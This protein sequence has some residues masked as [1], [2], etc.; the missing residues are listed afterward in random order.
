MNRNIETDC[1]KAQSKTQEGIKGMSLGDIEK[2]I[3]EAVASN[4]NLSSEFDRIKKGKLTKGVSR[5]LLYCKFI[6]TKLGSKWAQLTGKKNSPKPPPEAASKSPIIK[7]FNAENFPFVL[8][9]EGEAVNEN[10]PQ[11]ENIYNGDLQPPPFIPYVRESRRKELD[12]LAGKP[13]RA[14]M[15]KIDAAIRRAK[16][17]GQ[18]VPEFKNTRNKLVWFQTFKPKNGP[19]RPVKKPTFLRKAGGNKKSRAIMAPVSRMKITG[20]NARVPTRP[21]IVLAAGTKLSKTET[22]EA[23]KLAEQITNKLVKMNKSN[24]DGLRKVLMNRYAAGN[25]NA[26]LKKLQNLPTF[27]YASI[28]NVMRSME[29]ERAKVLKNI[30][31]PIA[32]LSP[33]REVKPAFSMIPRGTNIRD[34]ARRGRVKKVANQTT[35][36]RRAMRI[37]NALDRM[38]AKSKAYQ[39]AVKMFVTQRAPN[40]NSNSNEE[41]MGG[42]EVK[43]V[44]SSAGSNAGSTGGSPKRAS[45]KRASPKRASPK[46][47]ISQAEAKKIMEEATT[48]PLKRPA[49]RVARNIKMGTVKLENLNKNRLVSVA[50]QVYAVARPGDK[51]PF[52]QANKNKLQKLIQLGI[53]KL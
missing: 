7:Q 40:L 26:T 2:L 5:R 53:K 21:K 27:N 23:T 18:T 50:K 20:G 34:I 41:N 35:E 16:K 51:I 37:A 30:G 45:P 6:K 52:E 32:P 14:M 17:L 28:R 8:E 24:A 15:A 36:E 3:S 42:I 38:K 13:S 22:K 47:A 19:P 43:S 29:F 11:T 44:G 49:P 33:K 46:R 39:P 48:K 25:A 10:E 12:P 4:S 31:A 9:T 1:G